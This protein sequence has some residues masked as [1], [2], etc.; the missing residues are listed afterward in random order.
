MPK[1]NNIFLF[2][3]KIYFLFFTKILI[4]SYDL[5]LIIFWTNPTNPLLTARWIWQLENIA[6]KISYKVELLLLC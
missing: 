5:I 6:L 4:F 3:I 1:E 2:Y